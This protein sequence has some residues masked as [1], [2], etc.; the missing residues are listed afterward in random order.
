VD[1]DACSA[2]AGAT[3]SGTYKIGEDKQGNSQNFDGKLDEIRIY[4]R[5]ITA[6][7]AVQ[8]YTG[9][10][11]DE[12]CVD[13][14]GTNLKALYHFTGNANDSSGNGYNGTVTGAT[15]TTDKN[16]VSNQAYNFDGDSD[17]IDT[18]S[19]IISNMPYISV[20]SWLNFSSLTGT[21]EII[22]Q[23][24]PG[25]DTFQIR[26]DS[27]VLGV[28]CYGS[29]VGS[30]YTFSST[31]TWYHLVVIFNTIT[32]FVYVYVDNSL[33]KSQALTMAAKI[34]TELLGIGGDRYGNYPALSFRG[35]LDEIR[36][37]D[38]VITDDE[39]DLLYVGYDNP[40]EGYSNKVNGITP[41]KI[42]GIDVANVSKFNGI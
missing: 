18:S 28:Y 30:L 13:T 32:N 35:K 19:T 12:T 27:G 3:V 34:S 21:S 36:I 6:Y 33:V 37:Y 8:L 41:S 15:L 17:Y 40:S 42:N 24:L 39:I 29:Q 11:T 38:R 9:Y 10:D 23:S 14:L 22:Y 7:E 16:S 31:S 2:S 1:S 5:E 25:T 20:S 26:T 4:N